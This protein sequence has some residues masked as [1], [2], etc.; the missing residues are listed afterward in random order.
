ML[1]PVRVYANFKVTTSTSVT[2]EDLLG[3]NLPLLFP[4]IFVSNRTPSTCTVTV[5]GIRSFLYLNQTDSDFDGTFTSPLFTTFSIGDGL[6]TVIPGL[7]QSGLLPSSYGQTTQLTFTNAGPAAEAWV[8][9][10]VKGMIESSVLPDPLV[11]V[12]V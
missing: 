4:D 6:G 9:V 5:A 2:V 1:I 7:S 11:V 8:S 12:N 3:S 10:V